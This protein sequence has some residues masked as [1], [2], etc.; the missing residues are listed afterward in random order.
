ME[1]YSAG[2]PGQAEQPARRALFLGAGKP[3]SALQG[4]PVAHSKPCSALQGSPVAHSKPC[5][6]LQGSPVAHFREARVQITVPRRESEHFPV[7]NRGRFEAHLASDRPALF[8]FPLHIPTDIVVSG[9]V[10]RAGPAQV[11]DFRHGHLY[12]KFQKSTAAAQTVPGPRTRISAIATSGSTPPGATAGPGGP[13]GRRKC[14]C[15]LPTYPIH[16]CRAT[17]YTH[18]QK[19]LPCPICRA[20][21]H[22][23]AE[24]PYT[25]T[26]VSIF[27]SRICRPTLHSHPE[28]TSL[29]AVYRP[30]L[31]IQHSEPTTQA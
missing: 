27:S 1:H 10:R 5:S 26:Q 4:S 18:H 11:G 8:F 17:L 3:C 24:L 14:R 16:F 23:F 7:V 13:P 12:G 15:N 2:V 30:T 9:R 25:R 22:T 21:L 31:H 19:F 20:T 28:R 29:W 6:A